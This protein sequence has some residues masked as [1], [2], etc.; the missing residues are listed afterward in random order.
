MSSGK[1]IAPSSGRNK[2]RS[3]G[4]KEPAEAFQI[5]LRP[6]ELKAY[7]EGRLKNVPVTALSMIN[8]Q[9]IPVLLN[10]WMDDV[11]SKL[12]Y[13]PAD[14]SRKILQKVV[15]K[16]LWQRFAQTT[17]V[18][19]QALLDKLTKIEMAAI[20]LHE[21]I[22]IYNHG[23]VQARECLKKAKRAVDMDS[24]YGV[25][26]GLRA[27]AHCAIIELREETLDISESSLGANVWNDFVAGAI[28]VFEADGHRATISKSNGDG[29]NHPSHFVHFVWAILEKIPKELREHNSNRN[30][31]A[32]ALSRARPKA[33]MPKAKRGHK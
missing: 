27:S 10:G 3:Y 33:K 21:A 29:E 4:E 15:E 5:H 9:K 13:E 11:E 30:A 32:L 8:G 12:P 28:S 22:E 31:L 23:D 20:N 16:Y 2:T 26:T 6:G 25:V 7:I 24:V 17:S 18:K 1:K 19:H 14:P